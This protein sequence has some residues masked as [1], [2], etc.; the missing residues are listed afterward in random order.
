MSFHSNIINS[1]SKL[2]LANHFKQLGHRNRLVTAREIIALDRQQ[3]QNSGDPNNE[4][5]AINTVSIWVKAEGI[6]IRVTSPQ[7]QDIW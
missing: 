4:Q 3:S 6:I 2:A 5:S 1:S 7:F